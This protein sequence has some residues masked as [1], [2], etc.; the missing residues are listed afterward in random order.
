MAET[1]IAIAALHAIVAGF[2]SRK[3]EIRG[4][5]AKLEKRIKESDVSNA[6]AEAEVAELRKKLD[7]AERRDARCKNERLQLANVRMPTYKYPSRDTKTNSVYPRLLALAN[8]LIV[9]LGGRKK[10]QRF[11]DEC[12]EEL[13]YFEFVRASNTSNGQGSQNQHTP[14]RNQQSLDEE[15]ILDAEEPLI[16]KRSKLNRDT[17]EDYSQYHEFIRADADSTSGSRSQAVRS[18]FDTHINPYP[19]AVPKSA[20]EV[21]RLAHSIEVGFCTWITDPQHEFPDIDITFAAKAEQYAS[22]TLQELSAVYGTQ[23][24]TE[25]TMHLRAIATNAKDHAHLAKKIYSGELSA[26]EI[27]RTKVDDLASDELKA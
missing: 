15:T 1:P 27:A 18:Q 16:N 20:T 9:R 21:V 19:S 8:I 2:D 6:Q 23:R 7:E 5:C 3:E 4:K 13:S 26:Q 24:R 12:Q 17:N 10:I 22:E 14:K 25:Y 11:Y